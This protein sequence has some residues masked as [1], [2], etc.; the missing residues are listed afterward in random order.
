MSGHNKYD[1]TKIF[2]N[3]QQNDFY[4]A[5]GWILID[6]ENDHAIL[7][8]QINVQNELKLKIKDLRGAQNL[9]FNISIHTTFL[10]SNKL[11][12]ESVRESLTPLFEQIIQKYIPD[13]K[14]IQINI[15]NK[16]PQSG[17]LSPH[18]NLT[19]VDEDF[20]TSLSIWI[21]LQ[22]TDE[23]NGCLYFLP[24][25]QGKFEK[26]RNPYINW[27]P[28]KW[29][30]DMNDYPLKP[31]K[32]NLGQILIFNDSLV[33]ASPDN[34]SE[35]SRVSFHGLAI[36]NHASPIY[37]RKNNHQIEIIEVDKDFWFYYS[38][39]DPEP[40]H[41]VIKRVNYKERKYT[42]EDILSNE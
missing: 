14:I 27:P 3:A 13:H 33:H 28:L 26:Y 16:Q 37:P 24:N 17:Y 21:P 19:T 20:Y 10:D 5:N 34:F 11:Y 30:T 9:D 18:Q 22:D 36:P 7:E 42:Q 23:N 25:S 29:S 6:L 2:V 35:I 8:S 4:N 31:I 32:M 1:K 41:P 39:G 15:F 40:T 12:K 38:P